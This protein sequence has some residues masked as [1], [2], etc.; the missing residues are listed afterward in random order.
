MDG[1]TIGTLAR[2]GEVNIETIRFYERKGLIQKPPRNESGYRQFP[3]ETL[4]RI[5]F[6]RNAK[7]LGFSLKEVSELLSLRLTPN[8]SCADVQKKAEEKIAEIEDKIKSLVKIKK[9]L[10]NLTSACNRG[11]PV[12]ECHFLEVLM[13]GQP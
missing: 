7:E 8:T 11:A 9:A 13:K 10:K 12:D 6:I 3:I 4:E 1:L 5:K 2:E